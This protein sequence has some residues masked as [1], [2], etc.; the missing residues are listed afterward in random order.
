MTRKTLIPD[1]CS[2]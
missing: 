1:K 2:S